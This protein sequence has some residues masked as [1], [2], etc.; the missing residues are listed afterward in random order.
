MNKTLTLVGRLYD[1]LPAAIVKGVSQDNRISAGLKQ[2]SLVYGELE[3][4]SFVK[5]FVKLKRIHGHMMEP[6][7]SFWDLGAGVGKLVIAAAMGHN[8][9]SCYG[10]EVLAAL[11]DASRPVLMR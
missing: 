11:R 2:E 7:G 9:E 1:D 10:V 3:I 6:G 4:A 5:V 8:F